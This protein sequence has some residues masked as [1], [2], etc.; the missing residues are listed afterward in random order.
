[1]KKITDIRWLNTHKWGVRGFAGGN[2]A[3]YNGFRFPRKGVWIEAPDW[4]PEP[5]C[6]GGFHLMM[7]EANGFG[8]R[9]GNIELVEYRGPF[10]NLGNKAKVR[11]LRRIPCSPAVL[12][13]ALRRCN[14]RVM[15]KGEADHGK[16]MGVVFGGTVRLFGGIIWASGNAHIKSY[17]GNCFA[18][19]R[20]L[21]EQ[22]GGWVFVKEHAAVR[23]FGGGCDI[24]GQGVCVSQYAGS[25]NVYSSSYIKQ[26]GGY[27]YVFHNCHVEHYG[28]L[29]KTLSK[30]R[31]VE[32]AGN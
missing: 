18:Q 26:Y 16:G 3:E 19:N 11:E 10:I 7:P 8:F 15:R 12:D 25:T 29:C 20:V 32:R 2:R 21:L 22:Y 24:C 4:N 1:M 14:I 9:G 17:D 13:E 31:I 23:L 28:G 30:A 6:G 5:K 27:C